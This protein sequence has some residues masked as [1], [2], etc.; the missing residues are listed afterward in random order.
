VGVASAFLC[1]IALVVLLFERANQFFN[2]KSRA[3][4]IASGIQ[5]EI[6]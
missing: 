5:G 3:Q 4:V 2:S 6:I 1:E